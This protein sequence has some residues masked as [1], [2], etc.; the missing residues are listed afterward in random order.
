MRIS[1]LSSRSGISIATIKYYVRERLLPA[2]QQTATNQALYDESHLRRL[3]L[4]RALIEVGGL[5]VANVRATVAAVEDD[6]TPLHDAFG[7]VM[8]GLDETPARPEPDD[9]ANAGAEV[10]RWLEQRSWTVD[11]AAP[12]RRRLAEALAVLRRFDFPVSLADFDAAAQAAEAA[13]D[14]E[15]R[16]ARGMTDR[17]AAVETMLVGT[18]VYERALAEIRRLALEAVSA[19]LD[20]EPHHS[21]GPVRAATDL[22]QG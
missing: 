7:A 5:Q 2:G 14:F 22:P 19:G 17:T 21:H 12:A 15:V 3:R 8:H 13:A 4:V 16:Y 18:V 10:D 11:E 9:V 6:S 1:E 20:T